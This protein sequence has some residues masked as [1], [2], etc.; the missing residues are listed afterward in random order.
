MGNEG[1][2]DS[3]DGAKRGPSGSFL[4]LKINYFYQDKGSFYGWHFL[5]YW[6]SFYQS[7]VTF[8]DRGNNF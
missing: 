8:H 7:E 3:M 4:G 2:L 1:L 5:R 6:R